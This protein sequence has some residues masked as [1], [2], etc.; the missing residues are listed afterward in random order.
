MIGL[1]YRGNIITR[2]KILEDMKQ[3]RT[4]VV[5]EHY[6]H[7]IQYKDEIKTLKQEL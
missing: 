6:K 4:N 2:I 1:Q 3:K 5:E 7:I